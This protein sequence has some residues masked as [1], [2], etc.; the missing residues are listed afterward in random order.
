[1]GKHNPKLAIQKLV[2]PLC[3]KVINLSL[4]HHAHNRQGGMSQVEKPKTL[5]FL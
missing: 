4:A 5:S 3:S 2:L 1:M